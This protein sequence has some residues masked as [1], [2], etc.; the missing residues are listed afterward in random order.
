MLVFYIGFGLFC[1]LF[2]I[3]RPFILIITGTQ[4]NQPAR[5]KRGKKMLVQNSIVLAVLLAIG[6]AIYYL[7]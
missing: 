3:V 5:V 4:K 2:M 7:V 1:L 6:L